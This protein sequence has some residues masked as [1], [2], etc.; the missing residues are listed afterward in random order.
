MGR[1][2]D[3]KNI[4]EMLKLIKNN[5]EKWVTDSPKKKVYKQCHISTILAIRFCEFTVFTSKLAPPQVK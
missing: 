4:T 3:H 5:D 2:K 1:L